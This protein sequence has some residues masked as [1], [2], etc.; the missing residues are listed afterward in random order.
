MVPV[1]EDEV[2]LRNSLFPFSLLEQFYKL[3][4]KMNSLVQIGE[5]NATK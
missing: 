3:Y 1:A 5:L 2:L 4:L